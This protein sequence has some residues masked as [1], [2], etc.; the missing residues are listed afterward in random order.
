MKYITLLSILIGALG[1]TNAPMAKPLPAA[2]AE[3][4]GMSTE[5]LE[6]ITQMTQAYVDEGKLA[7]VIRWSHEMASWFI[8]RQ[9]GIK[10]RV[11]P[12]R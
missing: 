5:R 6:R 12:D 10:G 8:L 9:S 7:G 11:I 1:F 3:R 2:K 4:V